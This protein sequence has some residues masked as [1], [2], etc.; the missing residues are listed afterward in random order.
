M[1]SLVMTV[2]GGSVEETFVLQNKNLTFSHL[3]GKFKCLEH[4]H[5]RFF[6][7]DTKIQN[8]MRE[9]ALKSSAEARNY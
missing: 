5:K 8:K 4:I 9:S 7:W 2:I 1:T 3:V 6:H